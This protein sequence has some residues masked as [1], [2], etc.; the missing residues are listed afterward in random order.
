[1]RGA[2]EHEESCM[3]AWGVGVK[4]VL[5]GGRQEAGSV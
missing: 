3:P 1:M 4:E 5:F 2:P